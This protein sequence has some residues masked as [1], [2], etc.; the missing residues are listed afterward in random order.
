MNSLRIAPAALSAMVLV[1][2][3][4]GMALAQAPLP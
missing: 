2:A 1:A 4:T 3:S